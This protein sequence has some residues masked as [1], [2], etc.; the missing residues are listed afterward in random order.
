[1]IIAMQ[2]DMQRHTYDPV[3]GKMT[4]EVQVF[5]RESC[6]SGLPVTHKYCMKQ[7]IR[8]VDKTGDE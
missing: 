5:R 3:Y 7:C 1:M 2:E 8:S 4:H 6:L